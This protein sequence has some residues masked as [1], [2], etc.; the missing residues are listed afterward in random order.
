M[1]MDWTQYRNQLFATLGE[2]DSISPAILK[3]NELISSAAP[4][5]PKLDTKMRELI[6]LA[7]AVTTRCDGCISVHAA[8][9]RAA[10]ATKDE[11]VEVLGI[12]IALNSGAALIYTARAFDAFSQS[13][14]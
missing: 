11:L 7:V 13:S 2:I 3:A 10:G 5:H 12:A 8:T 14:D 1:M 6:A 4:A 9:A